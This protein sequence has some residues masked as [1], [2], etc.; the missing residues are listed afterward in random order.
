MPI[1]NRL[2]EMQ[3][4]I[5]AWRRH[6]HEN[7]ELMYDVH[8]TA[9][10]VAARLRDFGCDEVVTGIGKTGV[11]GVIKGRTDTRGHVV[12]LR[13]DM[14]ALPI[15][16][17]TGLPYASKTPARCTPAAMTGTPPCCWA[18][19]NTSPRRAIST[20]LSPSSSS[21]PRKVGVVATPWSR[22]A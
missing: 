3:P 9:A 6:L 5:A 22:T 14:D 8:D 17:A 4:E 16:E 1:K 13:A 2:A 18:R 12:G 19:R 15:L 21:Q 10:F 20:A 11:V 7:P